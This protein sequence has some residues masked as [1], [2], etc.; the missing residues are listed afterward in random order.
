MG[1]GTKESS[2]GLRGPALR[3]GVA[4]LVLLTIGL[5]LFRP[6]ASWLIAGEI[7]PECAQID[8]ERSQGVIFTNPAVAMKAPAL[9]CACLSEAARRTSSSWLFVAIPLSLVGAFLT[10]LGGALGPEEGAKPGT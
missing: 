10:L 6:G 1:A 9:Y 7:R 4:L 3:A 2:A 5:L 8:P